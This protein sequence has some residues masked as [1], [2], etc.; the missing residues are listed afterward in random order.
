MTQE[1]RRELATV[2]RSV[3]WSETEG[4]IAVAAWRASGE[5]AKQFGAK[6]GLSAR[7]LQWWGRRLGE[8]TP[9]L[10]SAGASAVE[11]VPIGVIQRDGCDEPIEIVV[12]VFKIRVPHHVD[13][14]TLRTVVEVLRSC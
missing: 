13:R 4:R 8:S 7:R 2:A 5:G 6:H 11:L 9:A 12:G 14:D 10:T 1:L 3:Y